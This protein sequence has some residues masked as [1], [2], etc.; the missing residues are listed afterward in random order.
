MQLEKVIDDVL[1]SGNV[2]ELD[3]FLQRDVDQGTSFKCSQQFLN[4]L[5]KLVQKVR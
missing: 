3:I 5:D 4:K 1:K 2:Q